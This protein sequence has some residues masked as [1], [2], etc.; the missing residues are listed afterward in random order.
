MIL[1][2]GATGNVG[3]Q[4]AAHLKDLHPRLLSRTAA[5]PG[6]FT[7]DLTDPASLEPALDGVDRVFLLWPLAPAPLAEPLVELLSRRVRRVV[8]LSTLTVGPGLDDQI[9]RTHAE[10]LDA[11]RKSEESMYAHAVQA[12]A[13]GSGVLSSSLDRAIHDGLAYE[14]AVVRGTFQDLVGVPVVSLAPAV[15]G[16]RSFNLGAGITRIRTMA[17][18]LRHNMPYDAP[19]TLTEQQA[20][21]IAAYVTAQPRP[22]FPDKVHDWPHGDPPPDLNYPTAA[23]RRDTR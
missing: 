17:G 5:G 10:R 20:L 18:F 16:M 23:G 8:L 6:A 13:L 3:R 4:T 12:S 11:S 21:D 19:G 14:D 22:D 7:G 15:W 9:T 1:I 2:T